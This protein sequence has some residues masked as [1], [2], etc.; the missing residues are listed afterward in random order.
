[1]FDLK[2]NFAYALVQAKLFMS[3]VYNVLYGHI[4][5][6]NCGNDKFKKND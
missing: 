4:L 2:P 1:M 6:T 3:S 5:E